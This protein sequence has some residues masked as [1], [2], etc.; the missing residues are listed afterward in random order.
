MKKIFELFIVAI[1]LVILS[2]LM[3]SCTNQS[4]GNI[5]D[6]KKIP[7][8]VRHNMGIKVDNQTFDGIGVLPLEN[9]TY[10]LHLKSKVDLDRFIM[11][12]CQRD[13]VIDSA[14]NVDEEVGWF[15]FKHKRD[16]KNEIKID[17]TP[18]WIERKHC[19]LT[20][21]AIGKDAKVSTGILILH[22]PKFNL[23]AMVS[24]NGVEKEYAGASFCE[25]KEGLEQS[26][27]FGTEKVVLSPDSSCDFGQNEGT[28]FQFKV[29][30]GDCAY[31]FKSASGQI[32]QLITRGYEQA[33]AE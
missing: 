6:E 19:P 8:I 10:S 32:H 1:G 27:N 3:F 15:I 28:Y 18:S 21:E 16:K 2:L 9:R 4:V 29:K 22:S 7:L 17:Y 11:R 23:K 24:C 5:F 26:I 30:K 25:V 20:F 12:S 14:W 33:F 13:I 31:I